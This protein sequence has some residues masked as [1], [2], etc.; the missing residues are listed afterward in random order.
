M[1]VRGSWVPSSIPSRLL[2]D[3]AATLR[4]TT[5]IGM[6]STWRISC[7]RM[8]RRRMKC[9]GTPMCDSS[10]KTCSLMR[11]LSTPLPLIVPFF[12]ALNAVA[13]SLKYWISVPGSGPS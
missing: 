12:C 10:V 1:I 5:S 6:I 8:L 9:V 11:L 2:S 13:S 3:P 4:I 7:S